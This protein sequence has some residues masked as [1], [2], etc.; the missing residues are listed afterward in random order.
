MCHRWRGANA[1]C[2]TMYGMG[3]TSSLHVTCHLSNSI[4]C[5]TSHFS[6]PS[7]PLMLS[8]M[9]YPSSMLIL[10]LL[11][12]TS[13][14]DI[15]PLVTTCEPVLHFLP[16]LL[17]PA[18]LSP[19]LHCRP[20]SHYPFCKLFLYTSSLLSHLCP[21]PALP[22][23][24]HPFS[25][26]HLPFTPHPSSYTSILS[27]PSSHPPFTPTHLTTEQSQHWTDPRV[28]GSGPK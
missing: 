11:F 21:S 10:L 6:S 9:Q 28:Q 19:L 7:S 24:L 8:P 17:S 20:F 4:I 16:H 15:Y 1:M 12:N 25:L 13:I 23:F 26:S 22:I 5:C 3:Q 18:P 2:E 27:L 14:R